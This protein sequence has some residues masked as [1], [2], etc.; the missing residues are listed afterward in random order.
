MEIEYATQG[1]NQLNGIKKLDHEYMIPKDIKKYKEAASGMHDFQERLDLEQRVRPN[2]AN[3]LKIE[4][5]SVKS[6]MGRK[7]LLGRNVNITNQY[8]C[9][10]Q[11][12]HKFQ[13]VANKLR[14]I[15]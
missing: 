5:T 3:Q 1:V 14:S 11:S 8:F 10:T 12:G 13:S 15:E 9:R 7:I 2:L 4:V 6:D